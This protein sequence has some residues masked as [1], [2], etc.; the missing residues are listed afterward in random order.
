MNRQDESTL[1]IRGENIEKNSKRTI[2]KTI[3]NYL[4]AIDLIRKIALYNA[5]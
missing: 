1:V 5:Q 3:K 2:L 4:N